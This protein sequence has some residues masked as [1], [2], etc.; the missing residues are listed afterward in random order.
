MA[1]FSMYWSPDVCEAAQRLKIDAALRAIPYGQKFFAARTGLRAGDTLFPVTIVAG[2]LHVLGAVRTVAETTMAKWIK[3][4][5]GDGVDRWQPRARFVLENEPVAP[6]RFG[7]QVGEEAIARWKLGKPVK[8]ASIKDI[9]PVSPELAKLL[10]DELAPGTT[11]AEGELRA[12]LEADA[13]NIAAA[14]VLADVLLQRGD[15]H[16]QALAWEIALAGEKS[17]ETFQAL[18]G[19]VEGW[20]RKH[21][22][23]CDQPGGFPYRPRLRHVGHLQV[24]LWGCALRADARTAFDALAGRMIDGEQH[25]NRR[26]GELRHPVAEWVLPR[27]P[28]KVDGNP[29]PS[30]LQLDD[31]GR[32]LFGVLRFPDW[33]CDTVAD[34]WLERLMPLLEP[35]VGAVQRRRIDSVGRLTELPSRAP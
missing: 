3:A 34:G 23:L 13:W 31:A 25:G 32:E 5:P 14:R 35:R 28:V 24:T 16:G 19:K 20:M 15:P 7:Q 22:P 33:G 27:Q 30:F 1:D 17:P 12:A 4:H 18:V 26:A 21:R 11:P 6:L 9:R 2:R 29:E 10:L 8:I